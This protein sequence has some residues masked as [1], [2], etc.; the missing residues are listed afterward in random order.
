MGR[1]L[2]P[3]GSPYSP[4]LSHPEE[5]LQALPLVTSQNTQVRVMF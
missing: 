3:K 2:H 1:A 5:V 4:H